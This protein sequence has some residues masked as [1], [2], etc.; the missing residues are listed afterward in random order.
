[1]AFDVRSAAEHE[2][3]R[4]ANVSLNS[5]ID[6]CDCDID[7]RFGDL[8]PGAD[9]ERSVFGSDVSGEVAVDTQHRFEADLTR[10]IHHVAHKA[11]PIVFINR[12]SMAVDE[13]R[14]AAFVSARNCW[15]SHCAPL[16]LPLFK[17][18][19][20]GSRRVVEVTLQIHYN[21]SLSLMNVTIRLPLRGIYVVSLT[22]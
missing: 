9:D 10:K 8:R 13:F 16:S 5:S 6:L 20:V 2:L 14:L 11:E 18:G 19:W 3:F 7:L 22:H 15:S 1:M 21:I 12:G 4:G 17:I